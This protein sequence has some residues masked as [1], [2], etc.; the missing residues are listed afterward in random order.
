MTVTDSVHPQIAEL[1][2]DD[3]KDLRA[4]LMRFLDAHPG[5]GAGPMLGSEL[6]HTWQELANLGWLGIGIPERLGGLGYG[7]SVQ[8]VLAEES[9]ARLSTLPTFTCLALAAPIAVA[10]SAPTLLDDIVSGS[11]RVGVAWAAPDG[12][13]RFSDSANAGSVRADPRGR[14]TGTKAWVPNVDQLDRLIV[15]AQDG[16][17][18]SLW[19]VD[20]ADPG[21]QNLPRDQV[22]ASRPLSTVQLDTFGERLATGDRAIAAL[23]AARRRGSVWLCAEAVGIASTMLRSAVEHA[24][25]RRQFGRLIGEYQ[26]VSHALAELYVDL[27]LSRSAVQWA[28]RAVDGELPDVDAAVHCAVAMALPTAVSAAEKTLQ[29]YGG[30]G[31]AWESDVH[32]YYKRALALAAFDGSARHARRRLEQTVLRGRV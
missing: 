26:A 22:D 32:W 30:I 13:G 16:Q 21:V 3:T 29:V 15:S 12:S 4:S 14:L 27:E 23:S 25:Q 11:L 19:L 2:E 9:A 18:L 31:M 28:A 24:K 20:T 6:S 7:A 10:T 5:P 17:D 8:T 1:S